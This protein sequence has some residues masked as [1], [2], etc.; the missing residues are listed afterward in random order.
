MINAKLT[1][2]KFFK[3]GTEGAGLLDIQVDNFR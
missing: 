1:K 3:E 2:L